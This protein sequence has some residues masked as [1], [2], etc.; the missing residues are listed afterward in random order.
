MMRK[1][2]L[3]LLGVILLAATNAAVVSAGDTDLPDFSVENFDFEAC[4]DDFIEI[5]NDEDSQVINTADDKTYFDHKQSS[6][7]DI[8]RWY[9]YSLEIGNNGSGDYIGEDAVPGIRNKKFFHSVLFY[10]N[11][12][13][14]GFGQSG[15]SFTEGI[16][17][18][19]GYVENGSFEIPLYEVLDN[20]FCITVAVDDSYDIFGNEW[21]PEFHN[22]MDEEDETNNYH[23]ICVDIEEYDFPEPPSGLKITSTSKD[24]FTISWD[25]S[26]DAQ[27]YTVTP[28]RAVN[29][30]EALSVQETT[31]T[32]ATIPVINDDL[33]C[34]YVKSVGEDGL[35]GRSTDEV[36]YGR[37][38]PIFSDVKSSSWY[39]GY[40]QKMQD[41]EIVNGYSDSKGTLTGEFGSSDSLTIAECL[42]IVLNSMDIE[43]DADGES[44]PSNIDYHWSK[45]FFKKGVDLELSILSDL[46]SLNPNRTV[47]RGEILEMFWEAAGM[48][49][50]SANNYTASDIADSPQKDDIEL[51]YDLNIT[52]GYS[53]GTYEPNNGVN[54]AEITKIVYKMR[55]HFGK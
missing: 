8:F 33:H 44:L 51:A 2:S 41:E 7:N 50:Y 46:S 5:F 1:I 30:G 34:V 47:T 25:S 48:K 18:G 43:L 39:F 36:C 19:D 14:D 31:A 49:T 40:L 45:D 26:T 52:E 29:V 22:L 3:S 37:N 20:N 12:K 32:V 24:E 28:Y 15:T 55:A 27:E 53:D 6:N 13:A 38:L 21:N 9:C 11:V 35:I 17:A 23:D 42:K 16:L 10:N 54:R 4:S